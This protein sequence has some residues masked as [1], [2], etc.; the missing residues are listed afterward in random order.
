MNISRDLIDYVHETLLLVLHDAIPEAA[1]LKLSTTTLD[2][3]LGAVRDLDE[4]L[5]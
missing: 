5:K 2:Q 1:P 4:V 3:I